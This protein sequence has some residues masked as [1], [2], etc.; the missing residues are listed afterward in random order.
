MRKICPLI[1]ILGIMV[2]KTDMHVLLII[3]LCLT[4][5]VSFKLGYSFDELTEGMKNSISQV[6]PAMMIFILSP[7]VFSIINMF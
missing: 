7:A 6:M 1:L 4:C 2:L 5:I 3:G